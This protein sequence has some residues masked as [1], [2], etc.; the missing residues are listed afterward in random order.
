MWDGSGLAAEPVTKAVAAVPNG[1][2]IGGG[3]VCGRTW[4]K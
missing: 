1:K 4:A 3:A 2:M